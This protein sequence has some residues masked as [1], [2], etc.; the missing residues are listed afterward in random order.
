[1]LDKL[2][3]CLNGIKLAEKNDDRAKQVQK[4]A[5]LL[6]GAFSN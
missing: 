1:V 5:E 3:Y 6:L 2:E 4:T